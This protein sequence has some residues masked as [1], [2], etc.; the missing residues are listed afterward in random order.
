[1]TETTDLFSLSSLFWKNL[2]AHYLSL[3]SDWL[4]FKSVRK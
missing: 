1:M 2:E 3:F 4:P